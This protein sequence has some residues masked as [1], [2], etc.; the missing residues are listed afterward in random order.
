M[1]S[2]DA[3][4]LLR[5]LDRWDQSWSKHDATELEKLLAPDCTLHA[6]EEIEV[7][8]V[9]WTDATSSSPLFY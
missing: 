5:S 3:A 6:G 2:P 4:T 1:A 9:P 7:F 8:I